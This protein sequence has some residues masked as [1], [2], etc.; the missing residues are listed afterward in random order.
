MQRQESRTLID[1][2]IREDIDAIGQ[3]LKQACFE[4]KRVLVTGGAGFLGSWLCDVFASLN[5]ETICVDN[6]S[7]GVAH[8]IDH[9]VGKPSFKFKQVDICAFNEKI[10]V[11]FIL[12]M[13]SHASP[14][15]YVKAPLETLRTSSLGSD[16]VLELARKS[17]ATVLLSSTSEVYGDPEVVPTPEGYVGRIDPLS[18][19]SCYSEGKRYAEALFMAF[20]RECGIDVRIARIFNSYGP[21]IRADGLYARAVPRFI[22]QALTS[23]PITVYGD[24]MQTRSFCY[25]SDT[26]S[27][28]LSLLTSDQ[29]NGAV[30]NI[31]N[32]EET[33]ILE[34]A[35]KI[36]QLTESQ[37]LI[38][39]HSSSKDD[40]RRRCPNVQK[41]ADLLQW[42]P[43]VL[44]DRG[45]QR[46]ID[47]FSQETVIPS[48]MQALEM[49]KG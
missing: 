8:N 17:D 25:V 30:L 19:R 39:F 48:Y 20:Q 6:L 36:K 32:Q 37:S 2:I 26:V 9:L 16:N 24:G 31:G 34:L 12:H 14:E 23:Q 5:A 1:A 46:T 3:G 28:L 15:E 40:P 7:T 47:W 41:A 11:D 27:G 10:E 35:H 4:G 44:L 29:A 49:Q 38:T 42:K 22:N 45:L 43:N 18:Q 33:T 13:A 21:R